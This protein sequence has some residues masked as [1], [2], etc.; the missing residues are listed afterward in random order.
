MI[1]LIKLLSED[2]IQKIAA[3]EV[4]E[5]PASIVKELVENSIDAG[6]SE[7]IVEIKNGGKSYIRVTDDGQGIESDQIEKAFLRHSTSKI[8]DFDDLYKIVSMGF[9]G[10]ALASIIAVSKLKIKTRT[11]KDKS[12]TSLDYEDSKVVNRGKVAMNRGTS[13]E[14]RDLFYNLPVREKFLKSDQA[15]ANKISQLMYSF[16]IGNPDTSLIYIRDNREVFRTNKNNSLLENLSVLFNM[17]YSKNTLDLDCQSDNYKVRGYI[18]NNKYYKGNRSM[19]Y[20]FVNGRYIEE[21][22]LTKTIETAYYSLIP[23]GRF[24]AF[25]LFIETSPENIDINIH[26][27]KQKIKFT[28]SDELNDLLKT[29][30]YER[31]LES[32]NIISIDKKEEVKEEIPK[33]FDLQSEDSYKRILEAYAPAEDKRKSL[34]GL[35]KKPRE[36]SFMKEL[37]DIDFNLVDLE[38]EEKT[39]AMEDFSPENSF[40]DNSVDL[41]EDFIDLDE[42]D[43]YDQQSYVRE[44]ED[45]LGKLIYRSTLFKKYLL[46]EIAKEDKLL[47]VNINA[48]RERI[49]YDQMMEQLETDKVVS[50]RLLSPL[51]VGL[52]IHDYGLVINNLDSFKAMGFS[53]DDF[54][55]RTVA[56]R[57]LPYS[58]NGLVDEKS[59][60]YMLDKL[61]DEGASLKEGL[62]KRASALSTK[63]MKDMEEEEAFSLY[64][65]LKKSS[66]YLTSAHGKRTMVEVGKEE[67]EKIFLGMD[68]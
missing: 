31:L 64:V 38:E 11:D 42:A 49:I 23:S 4:V 51:V 53:I 1:L 54:G 63:K 16:A 55:D 9:R 40:L 6:A 65:D 60:S 52:S 12:G 10:E 27:N 15:E 17:D 37:E 45:I 41:D 14:V 19:Q 39:E 59:F 7:I 47:I 32:Q 66:N 26:P 62:V 44:E 46:F 33:L 3:G 50:Q 43:E 21:D 67:F 34:E 8:D 61:E 48:A 20:F 30:I 36:K 58:L 28:F 2:T 18:S 56:I 29:A 35:E 22:D 24:P 57:E 68:I 5:R 25:Q 13:I